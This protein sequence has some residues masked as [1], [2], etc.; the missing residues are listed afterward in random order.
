[1]LMQ[2]LNTVLSNL[3]YFT[4]HLQ[5]VG[6]FPKPLNAKEERA[7]FEQMK[8]GDTSAKK[9]LVEHNLRLVAHIIKKYYAQSGEADDLISIGTI[10][11]I[12]AEIGRAHV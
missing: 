12:K 7:C 5:N 1:M 3:M 6:S 10:G 2:L 11:L 8:A 9:K 4:L